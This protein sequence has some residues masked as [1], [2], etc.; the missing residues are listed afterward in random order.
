MININF[1]MPMP[2]SIIAFFALGVERVRSTL[3]VIANA[4][5]L[6]FCNT[7]YTL[8]FLTTY[9]HLIDVHYFTTQH[10]PHHHYSYYTATATFV[11]IISKSLSMKRKFQVCLKYPRMGYIGVVCNDLGY[12]SKYFNS[13]YVFMTC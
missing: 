5:V 10:H 12:I 7:L 11:Q 2:F 13:G 6:L 1:D 9:S 4:F 3:H 8:S